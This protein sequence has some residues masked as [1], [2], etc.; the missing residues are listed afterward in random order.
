M[1][2][3]TPGVEGKTQ[4][5]LDWS[6]CFI[7]SGMP[8]FMPIHQLRSLCEFFL[9]RF[10]QPPAK[11]DILQGHF[12]RVH[13]DLGSQILDC[14]H[15]YQTHLRLTRGAPST[16]RADVGENGC[17]LGTTVGDSEDV[18]EGNRSAA[19]RARSA[20]APGFGRPASQRAVFC[21]SHAN[22]SVERRPSSSGHQFLIALEHELY[23]TAG[24]LGELNAGEPPAIGPE[25]AA[26][27]SAH[28]RS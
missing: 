5:A 13:A 11:L 19:L 28:D 16:L 3:S 21:G 22:L 15:G 17:V 27:A 7:T 25:L 2:A 20:G 26:E 8:F 10:G 23:G 24:L 14:G 4:S 9:I 1:A 6:G 12:E 18:R